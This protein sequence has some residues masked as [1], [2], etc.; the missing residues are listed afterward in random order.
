[1][2]AIMFEDVWGK[3]CALLTNQLYIKTFL[4]AREVEQVFP[5]NSSHKYSWFR[6]V[7]LH[8]NTMEGEW[9]KNIMLR[10]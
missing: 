1:M 3:N 7:T 2:Y 6:H 5:N 4:T 8:S 9:D 10:N